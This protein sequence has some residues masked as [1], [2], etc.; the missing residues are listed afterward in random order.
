VPGLYDVADW[1]ALSESHARA[2]RIDTLQV[3]HSTTTSRAAAR[4][5][6]NPG[7]R[8]VSPNDQL[9][10]GVLYGI[11]DPLTRRAFTSG[12]PSQDHRSLTVE[13][14]NIT[15][16]PEWGIGTA[17][18]ER[19]AQLFADMYRLGLVVGLFYGQGGILGH[20]DVPGSYAT[21]CPGPSMIFSWI[22]ERARQIVAGPSTGGNDMQ[23]SLIYQALPGGKSRR[24][25]L[26]PEAGYIKPLLYSDTVPADATHAEF[27][28]AEDLVQAFRQT[29]ASG[30]AITVN[31]PSDAAWKL[32]TDIFPYTSTPPISGGGSGLPANFVQ[33]LVAAIDAAD[34][35]ETASIIAAVQ[36]A[37]AK[38]GT[39]AEFVAALKAAL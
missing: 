1:T 12:S 27:D 32:L 39:P 14:D 9:H 26:I 34:D 7:G 21:A 36:A 37:A 38:G 30:A 28:A 3:H 19:L 13:T 33:Q 4:A 18:H 24:G 6:Y 20:Y 15:L 22:I 29:T 10:D 35:D 17:N 11:C 5:L 31:V 23:A 8:Q 25:L 16:A 2:A